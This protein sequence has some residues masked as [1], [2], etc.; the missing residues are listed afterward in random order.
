MAPQRLD[1]VGGAGANGGAGDPDDPQAVDAGDAGEWHRQR[2]AAKIPYMSRAEAKLDAKRIQNH[3][4]GKRH[5]YECPLCG[6][7]HLTSLDRRESRRARKV[8]L[9]G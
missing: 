9:G 8:V 6:Y 7:W 5:P 3:G 1:A 2:C 4:R